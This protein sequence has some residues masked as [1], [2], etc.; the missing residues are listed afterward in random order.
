MQDWERSTWSVDRD[1]DAE[2]RHDLV[3]HRDSDEDNTNMEWQCVDGEG[4]CVRGPQDDSAE[5]G[6]TT[7]HTNTSAFGRTNA[8]TIGPAH[9][10]HYT[11]SYMHSH[12]MLRALLLRRRHHSD[13]YYVVLFGVKTVWVTTLDA[14]HR[15]RI[16]ALSRTTPTGYLA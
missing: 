4:W 14:S 1:E 12:M 10:P 5:H 3:C 9:L 16:R 6:C 7:R 2:D 8:H 11:P 15:G 13:A